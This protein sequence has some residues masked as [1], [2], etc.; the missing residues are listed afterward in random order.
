MKLLIKNGTVIDPAAGLHE[1]RDLW[2]DGGKIASPSERP[3]TA[4]LTIDATGRVVCPGFIDIHMH[5]DPVD[6]SSQLEAYDERS[7]FACMLHMGGTTAVAGNCGEN[8]YHPADYL[9]L[10]DRNGAPVNVA[11]M[12]GH[13]FFRQR[14]GCT[15]RYAPATALQRDR[16]AGE[17]EEALLRGCLGVSFGIRYEPGMDARELVETAQGCRKQGKLISA[18]IRDDAE[19]VFGAARE[20]LDAGLRL[21]VPLQVSHIG[22]MAGFGQMERFLELIDE[23]RRIRSDICCDCY[24]YDAFST[25]LGSTTYDDGWLERY[26]CGYDVLELCMESYAGQPCTEE[27]FRKVRTEHPDCMTVCHVM[28]QADVDLAY[29]HEAVMVA[30]DATL[31]CGR[32]HPRACGTFPRVLSRYVRS[33]VLSMDDAI[34]RMTSMPARQL[35]LTKKGNL[36]PGSDADLVIFD[37][38]RIYDNATFSDPLAPPSGMDWVLIGGKPVLQDGVILDRR[39]GRS[40]R[41]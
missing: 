25:S 18:H 26:R 27:L 19:Y 29:R 34:S 35:G 20:F 17:M 4:D 32:G 1:V 8:K 9:D 10:V 13:G 41:G 28:R 6:A 3:E 23:Y 15:D 2:V 30:S 22:S 39:A 12:A 36:S 38:E 21:E 11:M 31:D 7:V 37:P 5:E 16:M 14:A 40:V 24:P 33:F